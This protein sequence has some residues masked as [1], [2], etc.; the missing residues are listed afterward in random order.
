MV[1][2]RG[3]MSEYQNKTHT[4]TVV[5]WMQNI[6]THTYLHTQTHPQGHMAIC[7]HHCEKAFSPITKLPDSNQTC[8]IMLTDRQLPVC[9]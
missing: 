6:A 2:E 1:I 8:L 5:K 9:Y 7:V 4:K 3:E